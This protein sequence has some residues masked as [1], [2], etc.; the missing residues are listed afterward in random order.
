MKKAFLALLHGDNDQQEHVTLFILCQ[1]S[2]HRQ[3]AKAL[4]LSF[5]EGAINEN[6]DAV[7]ACF[8]ISRQGIGPD[9][10]GPAITTQVLRDIECLP[11]AIELTRN[12]HI[13]ELL[14]CN[15]KIGCIGKQ[16]LTR[17]LTFCN[18]QGIFTETIFQ[19][20]SNHIRNWIVQPVA[21]VCVIYLVRQ[22]CKWRFSN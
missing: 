9:Y 14:T 7:L 18:E 12:T 13:D 22:L 4:P 20:Y 5:A 10:V 17:V 3:L 16:G 2:R 11:F 8:P 1:V 19:S 21:L 6:H 15:L